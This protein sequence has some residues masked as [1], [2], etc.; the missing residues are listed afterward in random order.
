MLFQSITEDDNTHILASESEPQPVSSV[1]NFVVESDPPAVLEVSGSSNSLTATSS[2]PIVQQPVTD[3]A[4]EE[5]ASNMSPLAISDA[6]DGAVVT[7]TSVVVVE[8]SKSGVPT[9]TV[10]VQMPE[11]TTLQ[12]VPTASGRAPVTPS[13]LD[14]KRQ[15][16]QARERQRHMVLHGSPASSSPPSVKTNGAMTN[17]VDGS[18]SC[19]IQDSTSY[20]GTR[21]KYSNRYDIA[22]PDKKDQCCIMM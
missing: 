3:S 18:S 21:P 22:A 9:S 13:S 6:G 8:N 11:Q 14:V 4:R 16:Q 15:R 1:E 5:S 2:V 10:N 7:P 17:G 20:V 12:P 19:R